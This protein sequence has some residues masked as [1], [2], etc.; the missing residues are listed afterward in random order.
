MDLS[1]LMVFLKN[2]FFHP[3]GLQKFGNASGIG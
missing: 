2:I 1:F 3:A